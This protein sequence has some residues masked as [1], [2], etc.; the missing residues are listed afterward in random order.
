MELNDKY[1]DLIASDD[2]NIVLLGGNIQ[3]VTKNTGA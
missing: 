3:I 2:V 1:R